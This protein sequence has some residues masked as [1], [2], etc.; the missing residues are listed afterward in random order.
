[1]L[2]T[3]AGSFTTNGDGETSI[4]VAD[5]TNLNIRPSSS[6][7]TFSPASITINVNEEKSINFIATVD[8]KPPVVVQQ[9]NTPPATT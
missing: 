2:N 4:V 5:G 7:Y 1:M 6:M 3:S 9:P 8:V